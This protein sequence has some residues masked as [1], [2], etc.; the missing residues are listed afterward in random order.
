MYSPKKLGLQIYA[1]FF[2]YQGH[3]GSYL[4]FF[5]VYGNAQSSPKAET[6]PERQI[7]LA[8]KKSGIYIP[9]IY[10]APYYF[11]PT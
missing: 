9:Q 2:N 3:H 4:P 8:T 6:G 1:Y 10:H 7:S 11:I 5:Q